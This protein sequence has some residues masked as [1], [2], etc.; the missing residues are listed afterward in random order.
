M[1]KWE[2]LFLDMRSTK[3]TMLNGGRSVEILIQQNYT[4]YRVSRDMA[5]KLPIAVI[6]GR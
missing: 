5:A 1:Q 3:F 4:E 6:L 2:C